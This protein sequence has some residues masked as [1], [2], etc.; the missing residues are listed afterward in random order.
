MKVRVTIREKGNAP[1]VEIWELKETG[2]LVSPGAFTPTKDMEFTVEA[3]IERVL[4][5]NPE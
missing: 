4:S 2:E 1:R 5:A 3:E